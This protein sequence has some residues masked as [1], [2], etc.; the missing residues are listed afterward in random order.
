MNERTLRNSNPVTADAGTRAD[1]PAGAE[2][3]RREN[4]SRPLPDDAIAIVPVR[5]VVLF[6]GAVIPLTVGR[7]RSRAAAQ[8][9]VRLERPLGVLLQNK[10]EI[11]EPGP[12]DLHWVGTSASVLRYITTPD[13]LHH[14]IAR[15]LRR[16]RVLQFLEGY[17]FTVARVQYIE[18]AETVDTEIEG[19]ARALRDRATEILK[20]LPQVPEEMVAAL[21]SVE[22]PSRLADFIAGLMDV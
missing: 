18:E 7:E 20:L 8:E 13:G 3:Q 16:F 17:P 2:G 21:Q 1:A 15:G 11:E 10:P 9:A 4:A 14:A 5:N 6:P 19:R 22:G 12:N